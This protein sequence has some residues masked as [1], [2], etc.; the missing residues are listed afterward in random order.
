M[1]GDGVAARPGLEAASGTVGSSGI[2]SS[3]GA[4]S[5]TAARQRKPMRWKRI[6][7]PTPTQPIPTAKPTMS[8]NVLP[9][10]PPGTTDFRP[11]LPSFRS[12]PLAPEPRESGEARQQLPSEPFPVFVVQKGSKEEK[13]LQELRKQRYLQK[14]KDLE[15]ED[16]DLCDSEEAKAG[17]RAF[18]QKFV[19][20]YRELATRR[21]EDVVINYKQPSDTQAVAARPG[22]VFTSGSG[23]GGSSGSGSSLG[24]TSDTAGRQRKP[25]QWKRIPRYTLAPPVRLEKPIITMTALPPQGKTDSAPLLVPSFQAYLPAREP[26]ETREYLPFNTFKV[27]VLQR[28]SKEDQEMEERQRQEWEERAKRLEEDDEDLCDTEE[29]KVAFRTFKV[30]WVSFYRKLAARRP[31]D[32]VFK[33]KPPS[34][35]QEE[36]LSSEEMEMEA[37]RSSWPVCP[38]ATHFATHWITTTPPRCTSLRW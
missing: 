12:L 24:A 2:G 3:L 21:P 7:R 13:E 9:R 38:Q 26:R 37:D 35:T 4:T 5:A 14:A 17:F 19:S 33:Y 18:K 28:G 29:A 1:E 15:E 11:Y 36:H 8:P 22:L 16:E 10:P 31:E 32:V 20:F 30:K 34:D 23:A 6:P 25:G 27:T